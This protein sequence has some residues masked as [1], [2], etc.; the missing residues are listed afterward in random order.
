MVV[1]TAC[2]I[3]GSSTIE[4]NDSRV[5]K[6]YLIKICVHAQFTK[7]VLNVHIVIYIIYLFKYK[8]IKSVST[9]QI[10][11]LKYNIKFKINAK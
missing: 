6:A 7:A 10:F 3:C 9:I 8:H 11:I 1:N 4:N 5:L 2:Y